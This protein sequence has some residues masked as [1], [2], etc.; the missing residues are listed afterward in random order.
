M[1]TIEK[2]NKTNPAPKHEDSATA[3]L[4]RIRT[5]TKQALLLDLLKRETG[6]TIA[7][8]SDATGWQA[9]S[10]RGVISGAV[11]KRLGLEV[12]SEVEEGRGRVYRIN[13]DAPST[14]G[15]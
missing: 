15:A 1:P 12:T 9:H 14:E 5:E 7:E 8:I 11:K 2:R 6:A 13:I 3:Q 10:V 4:P